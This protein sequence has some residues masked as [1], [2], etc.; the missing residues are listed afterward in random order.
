LSLKALHIGQGDEVITTPMSYL[1]STSSIALA[2]A[3][4][5]FADVDESLN[6]STSAIEEAITP[7]TKAILVVHLAGLPADMNNIMKLALKYELAVIEDCAQSFG[8]L[9]DGVPVGSLGDI[10]TVSFHPLKNLGAIG[11]GGAIF[12]DNTE[13]N[14]WLNQA[15]N[16]GHSSRDECEFWSINSR[17]DSLQARFISSQLSNYQD[18]LNRRRT[19]AAIYYRELKGIVS[20]P[21][22]HQDCVPSYNWFMILADNREALVAHLAKC[23]IETKIHYPKLISQLKSASENTCIVN[24]LSNAQ[25]KL[26]LILSLPNSEHISEDDVLLICREIQ[27]FYNL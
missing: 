22:I 5:V 17:L 11:D 6:I 3:T 9:Y 4:A 27:S 13:Q 2:G 1:A 26:E 23:A 16:H 15:R 10:A 24:D 20:F 25:H 21:Q 12:L 18:E 14:D 7:K 19:L 8:A